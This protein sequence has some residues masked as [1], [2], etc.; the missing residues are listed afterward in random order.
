MQNS[1]LAFREPASGRPWATQLNFRA[2]SPRR[3][4]TRPA[5]R[6]AGRRRGRACLSRDF[7]SWVECGSFQSGIAV[8]RRIGRPAT[9]PRLGGISFLHRF[10]STLNHHVHLRALSDRRCLRGGGCRSR[11]LRPAGVPAS[12]P[13][14]SSPSGRPHRAGATPRDPQAQ[15]HSAARGR[16]R[17]AWGRR[18]RHGRLL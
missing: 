12:S 5:V 1:T 11:L 14:H 9:R 17:R 7:L 10:G 15:A 4:A 2:L 6:A 16:D 18:S 8:I 13:V 3:R